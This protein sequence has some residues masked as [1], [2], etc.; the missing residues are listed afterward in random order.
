[1]LLQADRPFSSDFFFFLVL[2]RSFHLFLQACGPDVVLLCSDLKD[3]KMKW[4]P[5]SDCDMELGRR[6]V[7]Y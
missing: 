1:M 2:E 6:R 3:C 4:V 7:L 5:G